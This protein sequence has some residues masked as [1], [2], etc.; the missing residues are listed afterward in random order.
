MYDRVLLPVDVNH[1]ESWDKALPAALECAGPDGEIHLLG[2]VQDLGAAVVSSFLPEGFEQKAMERL[3][4]DLVA[5]AGKI[6]PEG[7]T[8]ETHV[9]HG[10]VPEAILRTAEKLGADL[11]VMASHTP[12]DFQTLLVGSNADK[13]V[14]HSPISVLTVR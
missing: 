2:I 12:H 7:V 6:V 14:R 10:H 4:A 9:A 1:P 5:L 13:V 3:K 11:I 8:S